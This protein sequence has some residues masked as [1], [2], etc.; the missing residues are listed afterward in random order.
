MIP[1]AALSAVV[2][3]AIIRLVDIAAF[4]KLWREER[5]E[6]VVATAIAVSVIVLGILVAIAFA[7]AVTFGRRLFERWRRG[8]VL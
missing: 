2:I 6:F 3:A 1:L 4:A 7:L 5:G 8:R